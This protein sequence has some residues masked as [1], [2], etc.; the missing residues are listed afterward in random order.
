[1]KK[2]E[3]I[4]SESL[5]KI[6]ISITIKTTHLSKKIKKKIVKFLKK[7]RE[8]KKKTEEKEKK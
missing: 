2:T 5:D 3:D 7:Q 8:R 1:M 6:K 4:L